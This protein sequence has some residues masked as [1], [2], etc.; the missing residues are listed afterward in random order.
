MQLRIRK[1]S[2]NLLGFVILSFLVIYTYN[3]GKSN[4]SVYAHSFE[5]NDSSTFLSLLDRAEVELLLATTNFPS[6]MTLALHHSRDAVKLMNILYRMDDD[7]I[8][9]TDFMNKYNGISNSR[10]STIHA[11]VIANIIDQVL[12]EYGSA[13]DIDYDLTNMSNMMNQK[14]DTIELVNMDDYQSA[15]GL[16]ERAYQV[17]KQQLQPLSLSNI[18]NTFFINKLEKNLIALNHLVNNNASAQN[19]MMFVHQQLHPSLQQA[20]DLKLTQ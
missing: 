17:F 11:L 14:N 10:N 15:L 19:L 18:N 6:N 7:V 20:Y 8:D 9:D 3:S 1:S 5:P 4:P 16:S 12:R 13:Y 2:K